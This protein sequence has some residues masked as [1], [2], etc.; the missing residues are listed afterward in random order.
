MVTKKRCLP[1]FARD[2]DNILETEARR[3]G[4][5]KKSLEIFRFCLYGNVQYLYTNHQ[6]PEPLIKRNRAYPQ[7][8]ARLTRWLDRL[9]QLDISVQNTA[10][11]KSI[12]LDYLHEHPTEKTPTEPNCNEQYVTKTF[13]E[14][15]YWTINTV[16]CWTWTK[17]ATDRANKENGFNDELKT[18]QRNCFNEEI[19]SGR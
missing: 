14:L 1:H 8:S 7:Y 18:D 19:Q 4:L 17:K 5:G 9:A 16:N 6:A 11:S 15:F 3:A 12:A 2:R 10:G 13:T